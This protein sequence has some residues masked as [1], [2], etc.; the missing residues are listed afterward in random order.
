MSVAPSTSSLPSGVPIG[1]ATNSAARTKVDRYVPKSDALIRPNESPRDFP[2]PPLPRFQ[3][4]AAKTAYEVPTAIPV[5]TPMSTATPSPNPILSAQAPYVPLPQRPKDS[6]SSMTGQ[7]IDDMGGLM[8]PVPKYAD[9]RHQMTM[10]PSEVEVVLSSLK[11]TTAENSEMLRNISKQLEGM[12]SQN[13]N[14][15]ESIQFLKGEVEALKK[16]RSIGGDILQRRSN[17]YQ[18]IPQGLQGVDLNLG[19]DKMDFVRM[20]EDLDDKSK[21]IEMLQDKVNKFQTIV[22]SQG[23]ASRDDL[24]ALIDEK[25]QKIS[26]LIRTN[27]EL[28]QATPLAPKIENKMQFNEWVEVLKNKDNQINYYQ[29]ELRR[30]ANERSQKAS[31][32]QTLNEQNYRLRN[33]AEYISASL[34]SVQ[35]VRQVSPVQYHT[36]T[37]VSPSPHVCTPNCPVPCPFVRSHPVIQNQT[38]TIKTQSTEAYGQP[39]ILGQDPLSHSATMGTITA[40]KGSP[41]ITY[42]DKREKI[43]PATNEEYVSREGKPT[44]AVRVP[45]NT[46]S[47]QGVTTYTTGH[48][49]GSYPHVTTY[50]PG[51]T[52]TGVTYTTKEER[53]PSLPK[54]V[55]QMSPQYSTNTFQN[56]FAEQFRREPASDYGTASKTQTLSYKSNV[57]YSR[58]SRY[59]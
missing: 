33:N 27:Q 34:P 41:S 48:A 35:A 39:R 42:V 21:R 40:I 2:L 9:E 29:E 10:S 56:T 43:Y 50:Q 24:K 52:Y 11:K 51:H 30:A 5:L 20:N 7:N 58:P 44:I 18:M 49:T 26:E 17:E 28:R 19:K 15:N 46:Y 38:T 37:Y 54:K 25:N 45:S 14:V 32:L 55:V 4:P 3:K 22:E 23:G 53:P 12:V 31:T 36:P 57:T 13:Q 8:I 47:T 59:S 16:E 6:L 1:S